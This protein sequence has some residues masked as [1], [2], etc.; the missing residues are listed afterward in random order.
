MSRA[1]RRHPVAA[2]PKAGR[3]RPVVVPRQAARPP[4]GPRGLLGL[5]RPRWAEDIIGELRKVTWPSMADTRYLTIVVI[6]VAASVGLMLA[7]I[8]LFFNW[9]IEHTLL[10]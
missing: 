7:G 3:R 1:L 9:F 6:L 4:A 5:L 10:R 8:D 2:K